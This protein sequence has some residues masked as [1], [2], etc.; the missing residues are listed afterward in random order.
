M[1]TL[2]KKTNIRSV[3]NLPC[4]FGHARPLGSRIIRY[5][6][7]GWTHG[8]TNGQMQRLLPPSLRE[9]GHN[10]FQA[11]V[12][13]VTRRWT[14]NRTNKWSTFQRSR[15]SLKTRQHKCTDLLNLVASTK[16]V[17]KNV[18]DKVL[19]AQ[20]ACTVLRNQSRNNSMHDGTCGQPSFMHTMSGYPL[21]EAT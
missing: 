19:V 16:T 7:D 12:Q 6:C 5:V 15:H 20:Q 1:A 21:Y 9:R 8:R 3:G 10:K 2:W 13:W 4:K 11:V 14:Q 17:M 18:Y